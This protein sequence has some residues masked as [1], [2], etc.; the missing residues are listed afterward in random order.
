MTPEIIE[1]CAR[2]KE[3]KLNKASPENLCKEYAK[4]YY[5]NNGKLYRKADDKLMGRP[6]KDGYL[7]FNDKYWCGLDVGNSMKTPVRKVHRVIYMLTK[8]PIHNDLQ[9]DHIDRIPDNNYPDNLQLVDHL[10][11]QHNKDLSKQTSKYYGVY[12]KPS[13]KFRAGVYG[14][15]VKINIGT[16]ETEI[17]AA[18]AYNDYIVLHNLD[19]RLN[20][21]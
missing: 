3:E 9:I 5:Y 12:K 21:L 11:N 6:D 15:K 20:L 7:I 10:S 17:E 1:K 14:N 2:I 19:K 13:G 4:Y 8:G 16:F 18:K